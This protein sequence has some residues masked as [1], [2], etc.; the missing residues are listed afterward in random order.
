MSCLP[1]AAIALDAGRGAYP[2]RG[3]AA[4]LRGRL[5]LQVRAD[6]PDRYRPSSSAACAQHPVCC[7]GCITAA[8]SWAAFA[9]PTSC[10]L[11]ST[12]PTPPCSAWAGAV[13]GRC[14]LASVVLA[15]LPA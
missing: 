10:C 13:A 1:A 15:A 11:I 3:P 2:V 7:L 14:E 12:R 8:D 9:A 5:L 6:P 4:V